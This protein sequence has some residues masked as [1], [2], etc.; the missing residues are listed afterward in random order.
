MKTKHSKTIFAVIFALLGLG[1]LTAT[2]NAQDNDQEKANPAPATTPS[3][4][5]TAGETAGEKVKEKA[6]DLVKEVDKVA[7]K[8]DENPKAK[9]AAAG[10][11]QPIYDLAEQISFPAFHWVAFTLMVAGVVGYALQLVLGKLVVLTRF[12]FSV[13]EILSDAFGLIISLIGLVLTTQAATENSSFTQSASSVLSATACGV[14]AGLIL[15]RWGQAQELQ[16]TKG[17]TVQA[18]QEARKNPS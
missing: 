6:E 16:A 18:A 1:I 17:R 9:Q 3:T 4:P 10:V 15:Y 5:D 12:G 14:I 13:S 2:V 11:L 8:V 7:K